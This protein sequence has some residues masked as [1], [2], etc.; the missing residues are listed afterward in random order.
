MQSSKQEIINLANTGRLEEART[1]CVELCAQIESDAEL[2]QLLASLDAQSS[3][4]AGAE[5][6]YQKVASLRPME[7]DSFYNLGLAQHRQNK[8]PEAVQS[9]L[10]AVE[11]NPNLFDAQFCLGVASLDRFDLQTALPALRTALQIQPNNVEVLSALGRTRHAMGRLDLAIEAFEKARTLAPN[12]LHILKNLGATLIDRGELQ[13]ARECFN[14]VRTADPEDISVII[15]YAVILDKSG[16][17]EQA[18]EHIEPFLKSDAVNTDLAL[19]FANLCTYVDRCDDAVRMLEQ[20]IATE[21]N[22]QQQATLHF[23]LG[24][25]CD[26]MGEYHKAFGHFSTG[27]KLRAESFDMASF[28]RHIDQ[29]FSSYSAPFLE[30][31]PTSHNQSSKPVFI[32]GMPRS[33]TTLVEQILASHPG[34]YAAGESSAMLSAAISLPQLLGNPRGHPQ[35]IDQATS[36]ILEELAEQYLQ[37]VSRHSGDAIRIIDKMPHNFLRLGLIQLMFPNARVIHCKRNPVDTCLSCYA[38]DFGGRHPYTRSPEDIGQYYKEYERLME[39]WRTVLDIPLLEI[40]YEALVE[41]PEQLSRELVDFCGLE[42][43]DSC[44]GFYNNKRPTHTASYD[45]VRQPI[46][47]HAVERWRNYEEYLQPLIGIFK[48]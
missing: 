20:A 28:R 8:L 32:V 7:A 9:Y 30:Q 10:K 11:L 22:A 35:C 16:D 5:T 46:Y 15:Q 2:W 31:A 29:F 3:N 44:L 47:H 25:L 13:K 1:A 36:A 42:W 24:R 40:N 23:R 33:G 45:Q 48:Q 37:D 38:Q 6:A 27:H 39:H 14:K 43:D 26:S 12:D 4:M 41:N 18:F 19:I 34:I 17:H 21:Q